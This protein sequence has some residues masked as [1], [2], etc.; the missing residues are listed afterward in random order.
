MFHQDGSIVYGDFNRPVE[1]RE[2]DCADLDR[3][4]A[5]GYCHVSVSSYVHNAN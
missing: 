4:G 5:A 1:E 2:G 3:G